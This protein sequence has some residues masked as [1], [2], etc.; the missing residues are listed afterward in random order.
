MVS[1]SSMLLVFHCSFALS[2]FRISFFLGGNSI[3]SWLEVINMLTSKPVLLSVRSS[4]HGRART[5]RKLPAIQKYTR[6]ITEISEENSC[7]NCKMLFERG[8]KPLFTRDHRHLCSICFDQDMAPICKSCNVP[9]NE[10][11]QKHKFFSSRDGSKFW[12]D[13]C[14]QCSHCNGLILKVS[15]RIRTDKGLFCPKCYDEALG[16]RCFTCGR[17]IFKKS[18]KQHE[19]SSKDGKYHWHK[20]CFSCDGCGASLVKHKYYCHENNLTFCPECYDV[21]IG[22]VC[23]KCNKLIRSYSSHEKVRVFLFHISSFDLTCHVKTEVCHVE[24]II[25]ARRLP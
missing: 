20:E 17:T 13:Y 11:S 5:S 8:E 19:V 23:Y 4:R 15:D 25:L 22:S 7:D 21:K 1:T 3:H 12:H 10:H 18:Q 2:S 16:H 14:I 6:Q 9:I 24:W